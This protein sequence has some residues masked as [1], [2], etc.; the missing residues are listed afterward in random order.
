MTRVQK[1]RSIPTRLNR[2]MRSIFSNPAL[3]T[4]IS[5][6]LRLGN[7]NVEFAFSPRKYTH[8]NAPKAVAPNGISGKHRNLPASIEIL[9]LDHAL[10]A[11]AA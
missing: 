5:E 7:T 10:L 6:T 2:P 9:T 8:S 3:L 11:N 1:Y 4:K